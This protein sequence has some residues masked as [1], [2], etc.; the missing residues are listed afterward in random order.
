MGNP[1]TNT[2]YRKKRAPSSGGG[3]EEDLHRAARAGDIHA[4]QSIIASNPSTV[5]SRDK[6]SRTP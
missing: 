1:N 3:A 5:N 6:H 4:V 2:N